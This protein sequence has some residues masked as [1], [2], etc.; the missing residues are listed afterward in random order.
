M[1]KK[2]GEKVFI[3]IDG[4]GLI[5]RA[6]HAMPQLT[7]TA[8][9]STGAVYGFFSML[10]K[11]IQEVNPTYVAITFD[12]PKP[13][14]RKTLFVGYQANRPHM[15]STLS[16]Q[17]KIIHEV[18]E[19]IGIPV[20]EV[21]GFEA[22]DVIGTLAKRVIEEA[23][24]ENVTVIIVSADRDMHQLVNPQ[25]KVLAP[26]TGIS[27]MYLYD[28]EKVREKFGISPGQIVQYKSLV[29]DASDNYVGV[30]GIGPKTAMDLLQKYETLD[31]IYEHIA[32][33]QEKNP[34][35]AQKLID[36]HDSAVISRTLATIVTD[37]PFTFTIPEC[38]FSK[39]DIRAVDLVF[40]DYGFTSLRKRLMDIFP[41]GN[42]KEVESEKVEKKKRPNQLKLLN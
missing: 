24:D 35:L 8:G 29:G 17:I 31:G 18:V 41:Q 3:I 9:S 28:E 14:F 19:K 12:R 13:T 42:T 5:H 6:Y 26:V 27:K 15:E 11:I 20:Y 10:F 22:D 16:D 34:R 25:V 7:N 30:P 4:N 39:I 40:A 23:K 1:E 36:G 21:D 2:P 37:V 32:D 38:E 33:I